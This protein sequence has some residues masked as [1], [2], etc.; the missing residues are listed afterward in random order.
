MTGAQ[1]IGELSIKLADAALIAR[2]K[3]DDVHALFFACKAAECLALAKSLGWC[4]PVD[5]KAAQQ[6]EKTDGATMK[7]FA[8][9]THCLEATPFDG[10]RD[11]GDRDQC[12]SCRVIMDVWT[13][14]GVFHENNRRLHAGRPTLEIL[15][16]ERHSRSETEVTDGKTTR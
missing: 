4:P 2:E 5:Q 3:G 12:S 7:L 15:D 14:S 8:V 6:P 11:F 1:K 10:A 9:C 16:A 13:E